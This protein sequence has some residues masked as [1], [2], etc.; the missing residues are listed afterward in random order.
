MNTITLHSPDEALIL[1]PHSLGYYPSH[2]LVFFALDYA[3]TK[4]GSRESFLGPIHTIDLS[5]YPLQ[6][7]MGQPFAATIAQFGVRTC[8]IAAY[9]ESIDAIAA[10]PLR[11]VVQSAQRAIRDNGGSLC[12]AYVADKHHWARFGRRVGPPRP[13]SELEASEAAAQ[14]VFEGSAP[15]Q[16]APESLVRVRSENERTAAH[17]IGRAWREKTGAE[18]VASGAALWADMLRQREMPGFRRLAEANAALEFPEVRDRVL[19]YVQSA[20]LVLPDEYEQKQ[21]IL[22]RARVGELGAPHL[23]ES[24]HV[25]RLLDACA[26]IASDREA[27]ALAAGAYVCWWI[28]RNSWAADRASLALERE[29]GY[30]LAV[31]LMDILDAGLF[32]EW[33]ENS[34]IGRET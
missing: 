11:A 33:V 34:L 25:L 9:A 31:L 29:G 32:P 13:W 26:E 15:A 3:G 6:A 7:Q 18:S 1:I 22:H 27:A 20:A 17:T 10:V 21:H 2:H 19:A 28:G 16:E 24:L 14:L 4:A 30:T 12:Q 8:V 23:N 5:R